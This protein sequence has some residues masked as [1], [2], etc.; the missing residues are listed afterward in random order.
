MKTINAHSNAA[1][2][3]FQSASCW[4]ECVEESYERLVAAVTHFATGEQND[5]SAT[6][7]TA[8]LNRCA[9]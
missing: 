2:P 7:S 8:T 6:R 4:P 5:N 3:A 9:L 1:E